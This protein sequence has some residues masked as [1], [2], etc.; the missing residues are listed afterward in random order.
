[1]HAAIQL[2]EDEGEAESSKGGTV[3]SVS[4]IPR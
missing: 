1:M 3:K 4:D 2:F